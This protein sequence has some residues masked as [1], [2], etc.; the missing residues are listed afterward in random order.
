MPLSPRETKAV[1]HGRLQ[2]LSGQSWDETP[3]EKAS[4]LS[5]LSGFVMLLRC[6]SHQ[7]WGETAG[8]W[9]AFLPGGPVCHDLECCGVKHDGEQ[10]DSVWHRMWDETLPPSFAS[11][12]CW[13]NSAA[14]TKATSVCCSAARV[15]VMWRLADREGGASGKE[16]RET[17]AVRSE[18]NCFGAGGQCDFDSVGKVDT[19]SSG[20]TT[21]KHKEHLDW[22]HVTVFC[23][24]QFF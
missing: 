6:S 24:H 10:R 9:R 19:D 2:Y 18:Q 17:L 21:L 14:A 15:E 11:N 16:T 13:T 5:F 3:E 7:P 20:A 12:Y 8:E 1:K 4:I 22:I 23:T